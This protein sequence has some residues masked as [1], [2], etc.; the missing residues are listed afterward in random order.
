MANVTLATP[1]FGNA[2]CSRAASSSEPRLVLLVPFSV[3]DFGSQQLHMPTR[4][5][6]SLLDPFPV[7]PGSLV[8]GRS[9]F[10]SS[11]PYMV[12]SHQ[13]SSISTGSWASHTYRALGQEQTLVLA[14]PLLSSSTWTIAS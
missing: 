11:R 14:K 8:L 12:P 13:R 4:T 5:I 3:Q 9:F 2:P 6:T 10:M 7:A 1:T